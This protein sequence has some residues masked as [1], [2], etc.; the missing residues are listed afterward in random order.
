MTTVI[1]RIEGHY[2]V[3]QTPYGRDY[4]WC[5]ECII[6]ECDCGER[7]TLT[8]S[9]TTCRCGADHTTSV[10]ERL[11]VRRAGP[12]AHAPLRDEHREWLTKKD[13][14]LRSESHDWLEWR[15]IE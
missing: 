15:V 13:E 4:A 5:P 3:H 9:K 8:A 10:L 12:E 7:L 14:Y 6:V 2:E 1:E 11:A